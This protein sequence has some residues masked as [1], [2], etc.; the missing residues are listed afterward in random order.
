MI[1]KQ[2]D[3]L[4]RQAEEQE[5]SLKSQEEE[6]SS[7]K[8]ELEGL[9]QEEARLEHQ[10]EDFR[11]KLDNLSQNLQDSQLQISQ[12]CKVQ[13]HVTII[14]R[15]HRGFTHF[16]VHHSTVPQKIVLRTNICPYVINNF[17]MDVWKIHTSFFYLHE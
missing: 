3:N 7:K 6:L 1:F 13:P 4:R 11:K 5:T 8:Q 12:V 9:K 15:F 2:V 14:Q 16:Y 10:Q 17:K